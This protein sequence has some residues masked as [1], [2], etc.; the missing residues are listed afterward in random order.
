MMLPVPDVPLVFKV[1]KQ[2]F[3]G[4]VRSDTI[5]PYSNMGYCQFEFMFILTIPL[6]DI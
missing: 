2:A 3:G 6:S 1:Q 4:E 5:F